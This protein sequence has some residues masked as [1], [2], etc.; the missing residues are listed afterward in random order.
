MIV[1]S[2]VWYDGLSLSELPESEK[3]LVEGAEA[4]AARAFKRADAMAKKAMAAESGGN[5]SDYSLAD[6]STWKRASAA[7]LKS[8]LGWKA[9]I[10]AA[11]RE[12]ALEGRLVAFLNERGSRTIDETAL[13]R[14][15]A[16]RVLSLLLAQRGQKLP[17]GRGSKVMVDQFVDHFLS[18]RPT[19]NAPQGV[20]S[21]NYDLFERTL[22]EVRS[23]M[24]GEA[25]KIA[26]ISDL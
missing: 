17:S 8:Y 22:S 18:D 7:N 1:M 9:E 6:V 11:L 20:L 10:S 3:L 21:A 16:K 25:S 14:E 15:A 26:D 23:E 13:R 4:I 19:K 12:A 2:E 5:A 24:I